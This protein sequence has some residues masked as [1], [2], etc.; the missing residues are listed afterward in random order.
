VPPPP[1]WDVPPELRIHAS[2]SELAAA[3]K[4]FEYQCQNDFYNEWFW[5]P[6]QDKV[7][8]NCWENNG[9]KEKSKTITKCK[10][11]MENLQGVMGSV[12]NSVLGNLAITGE[13]QTKF[14]SWSAMAV[15]PDMA[16][17]KE[18]ETTPVIE[19]FYFRRGLHNMPMWDMEL[20][21]PIPGRKDRQDKPD[22]TVVNQA[23]WAVIN[24]VYEWAKKDEYPLRLGL[25]MHIMAHSDMI[26]AAQNGNHVESGKHRTFGSVTINI[27]TVPQTPRDQWNRC[28]QEIADIWHSYTFA[29]GTPLNVRAHWV[30]EW[31]HLTYNG[32]PL[33]EHY[34]TVAYKD[35]I[36][37]FLG[38]LKKIAA[39]GGYR[40]KDIRR[41]FSNPILGEIVWH[42]SK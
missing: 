25:A 20:I 28:C 8:V 31:Q 37:D 34:R 9:D 36:H 1:G 10:A 38:Q 35:R 7:F 22:W 17:A 2:S 24:K 41:L 29:D 42:N 5:F 21:I 16:G 39:A 23:W 14:V 26:M 6:F 30:K 18:P 33:T 15:L 13:L 32:V 3:Q 11:L 27:S 19:A 4:L 12:A 40:R